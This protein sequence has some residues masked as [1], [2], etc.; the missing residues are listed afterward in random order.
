M[1]RPIRYLCLE[2]VLK[3]VKNATLTFFLDLLVFSHFNRNPYAS[4]SDPLSDNVDLSFARSLK[5]DL[6][7]LQA[8][9]VVDPS[10]SSSS[11]SSG[12][13]SIRR[14]PPPELCRRLDAAL[15]HL[16]MLVAAFHAEDG[17]ADERG[18]DDVIIR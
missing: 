10:P 16:D 7:R 4:T 6:L 18:D 15:C 2:D 5:L 3:H 8:S 17:G 9:L 11:S 13:P 1:Y 14:L 12:R